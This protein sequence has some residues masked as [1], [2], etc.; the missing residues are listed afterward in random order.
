MVKINSGSRQKEREKNYCQAGSFR[1]SKW[2]AAESKKVASPELSS[3]SAATV[4]AP[5]DSRRKGL[6]LRIKMGRRV[7]I[8]TA[9]LNQWALDLKLFKT[10]KNMGPNDFCKYQPECSVFE[11]AYN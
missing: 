10:S 6:H 5:I 11:G 2:S 9:T 4:L 7:T 1:L 8:A 3:Y